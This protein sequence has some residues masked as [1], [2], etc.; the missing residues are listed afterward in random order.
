M[1]KRFLESVS[2][3]LDWMRRDF[4]PEQEAIYKYY[5]LLGEISVRIV[6]YRKEHA[7]SQAQLAD[8]LGITQ[9]MVSRYESGDYNF[10][11]RTLNDLCE[12]L[13]LSLEIRMRNTNTATASSDFQE[14][15]ESTD[16]LIAA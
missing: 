6:D 12:K 13:G 16:N 11:V 7:L 2:S 4:T 5:D 14:L 9:A 8:L 10:S 1:E 3:T 15:I